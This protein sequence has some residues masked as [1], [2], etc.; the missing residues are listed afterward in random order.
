MRP[1]LGIVAATMT[2]SRRYMRGGAAGTG[3][4]A[5]GVLLCLDTC[6]L[7]VVLRYVITPTLCWAPDIL[8]LV[9]GSPKGAACIT[10]WWYCALLV[11][12]MPVCLA[13]ELALLLRRNWLGSVRIAV[14]LRVT[15][16]WPFL[17]AARRCYRSRCWGRIST[18]SWDRCGLILLEAAYLASI[19]AD[20]WCL[21]ILRFVRAPC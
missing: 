17:S 11:C 9:L 20:L 7:Q 3:T 21:W 14:A 15:C 13:R 5:K 10:S 2:A 6:S 16:V 12:N 8:L 18:L 1:R 19:A 4:A